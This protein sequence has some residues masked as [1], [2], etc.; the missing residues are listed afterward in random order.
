MSAFV[1]NLLFSSLVSVFVPKEK[2]KK[3]KQILNRGLF[4]VGVLCF[5]FGVFFFYLFIFF[6]FSVLSARKVALSVFIK[7]VSFFDI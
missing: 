4:L 5:M 3:K 7:Q 6:F 1:K 2:E